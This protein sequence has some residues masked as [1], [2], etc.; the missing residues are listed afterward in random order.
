[1]N[2]YRVSLVFIIQR[3]DSDIFSPNYIKDKIYSDKLKEAYN[4][5]VEIYAYKFRW[6]I[7]NNIAKCKYIKKLD[8]LFNY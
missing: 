6:S 5:G 2:G 8:I 7:R 4:K 1:M 3:S